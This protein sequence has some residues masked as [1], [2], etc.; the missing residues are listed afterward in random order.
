MESYDKTMTK[1][2]T[3]PKILARLV[4]MGAKKQMSKLD[5]EESQLDMTIDMWPIE[6]ADEPLSFKRTFDGYSSRRNLKKSN[7]QE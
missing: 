4:T 7:P 5:R 1:T 6:I 3:E 2:E